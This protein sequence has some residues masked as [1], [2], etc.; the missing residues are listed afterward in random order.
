MTEIRV[1]PVTDRSPADDAGRAVLFETTSLC[2]TTY[3]TIVYYGAFQPALKMGKNNSIY[4]EK[5]LKLT[6]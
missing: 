4:Y 2:H 3:N 5:G 1:N 6:F